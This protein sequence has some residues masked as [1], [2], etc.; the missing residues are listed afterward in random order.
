VRAE[1]FVFAHVADEGLVDGCA[2]SLLRHR[3]FIGAQDVGVVVDLR[4]KHRCGVHYH[5]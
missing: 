5:E 1:G 2:A 3:R 4:K